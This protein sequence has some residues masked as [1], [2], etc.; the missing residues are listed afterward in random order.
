MISFSG[1][2]CSGKSTQIELMCNELNKLN[3]SFKVVWSRGGYTPFINFIKRLFRKN[4]SKNRE[5]I[6]GY[7][8]KVNNNEAKRRILYIFSLIDLWL[9]Y[10]VVLRIRSIFVKELICDR[11]IWD[12]YIDFRLKYPDYNI[13]KSFWWRLVLKTMIKP[14]VSFLLKIPA[15]VSMYRS[16]L[17]DEPF[18][19]NID[20]RETRIEMYF[21]ESNKNRWDYIIDANKSIG[22]VHEE[23]MNVLNKN[24]VKK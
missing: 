12:T 5:D 14:K 7:S 24:K 17:K 13:D 1:I 20:I 21:E 16:T 6:I 9:Y 3:V 8:H 10:S 11:Y 18:P 22:D 23:I 19:E 4:K 2:D 15:E